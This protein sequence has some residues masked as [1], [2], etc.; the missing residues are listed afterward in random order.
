VFF[1]PAAHEPVAAG[2][3]P[4]VL[5]RRWPDNA[6]PHAGG[7]P[8]TGQQSTG[9]S[10][11]ATFPVDF[12][13]RFTSNMTAAGLVLFRPIPGNPALANAERTVTTIDAP[14]GGMPA[15]TL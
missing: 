15:M 8:G 11:C 10:S 5:S 3:H 9:R 14:N 2:Q 7:G 4:A 13:I 12:G 6:L 1:R